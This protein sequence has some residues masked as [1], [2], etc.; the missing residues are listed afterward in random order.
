MITKHV[1]GISGKIT[2]SITSRDIVPQP[3]IHLIGTYTPVDGN[4]VQEI[5]GKSYNPIHNVTAKDGTVHLVESINPIDI[6]LDK[7]V[8]NG[9]VTNKNGTIYAFRKLDP[10]EEIS[11]RRALA[12]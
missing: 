5:D 12:L 10:Q 6:Q 4:S 9:T 3:A 11:V 8:A 1:P 2:N 7:H